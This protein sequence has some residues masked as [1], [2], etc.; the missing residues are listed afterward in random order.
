[1][2]LHVVAGSSD[3]WQPWWCYRPVP[4]TGLRSRYL[5]AFADRAEA[6]AYLR[7]V[8][9]SLRR[10]MLLD[11]PS[12]PD[13]AE[14]G[15]R[16]LLLPERVDAILRLLQRPLAELTSWPEGILRDWFEEHGLPL[17]RGPLRLTWAERA[18]AE[19]RPDQRAVFLE[20]FDRLAFLEVAEVEVRS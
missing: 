2:N 6:L 13:P 8:E 18:L 9:V 5:R 19:A 12:I 3:W 7:A 20:P 4:A 1:M 11:D 14:D 15:A 10:A 16:L 17:P